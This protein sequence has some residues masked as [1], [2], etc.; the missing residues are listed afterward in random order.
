MILKSKEK[1][2]LKIREEKA[3]REAEEKE[4]P[5]GLVN[6]VAAEAERNID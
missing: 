1:I 6:A 3:E 5:S 4:N 2:F